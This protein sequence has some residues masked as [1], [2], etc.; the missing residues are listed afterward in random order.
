MADITEP[1]VPQGS[2]DGVIPSNEENSAPMLDVHAPHET[3]HSWKSFLS[4]ISAIVVG[5]PI[6]AAEFTVR[7]SLMSAEFVPTIAFE[8]RASC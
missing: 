6:A 8:V 7:L 4:H 3:I 5:L 1:E 2:V